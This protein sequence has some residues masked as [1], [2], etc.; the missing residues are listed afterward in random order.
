MVTADPAR[1]GAEGGQI[2]D[3]VHPGGSYP[4]ITTDGFTLPS[5]RSS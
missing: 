2:G 3:D 4:A 1:G 5:G